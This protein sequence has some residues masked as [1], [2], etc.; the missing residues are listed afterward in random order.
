MIGV[1]VRQEHVPYCDL[2]KDVALRRTVLYSIAEVS[3]GRVY[4]FEE[5]K[6]V[7]LTPHPFTTDNGLATPTMKVIRKQAEKEF[8]KEIDQLY[9]ELKGEQ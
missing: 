1:C 3:R 5:P 4:R 7:F 6:N 9:E 8:R 2:L